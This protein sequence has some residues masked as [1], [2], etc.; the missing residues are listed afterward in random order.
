M[1]VD[2]HGYSRIRTEPI[3]NKYRA[4]NKAISDYERR[5][6]EKEFHQLHPDLKGIVLSINGISYGSEGHLIYPSIPEL[7]EQLQ[8]ELY[9]I[10]EKQEDFIT[11]CWNTNTIYR[12]TPD[13]KECVA[14]RSYSGYGD[15]IDILKKLNEG[16]LPY[17]PPSIDSAPENGLVS[18]DK[19]WTCLQTL[20]KLRHHFVSD[21]WQPDYTKYINYPKTV[22]D[23]DDD[24]ADDIH[25]HSWFFRDFYTVISLGAD[26]G[27][28]RIS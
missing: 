27:F 1:G 17:I 9:E 16:P 5:E 10:Y 20:N 19:C 4:S 3:P 6:F 7:S 15:F 26:G 21:S 12:R 8:D 13:T 14:G 25:E 22:E 11:V 2:F 28:V 18:S 24:K 23:L